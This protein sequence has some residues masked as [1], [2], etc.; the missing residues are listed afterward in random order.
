MVRVALVEGLKPKYAEGERQRYR[1]LLQDYSGVDGERIDILFRLIKEGARSP[2]EKKFLDALINEVAYDSGYW[3]SLDYDH[4]KKER[5]IIAHDG[6]LKGLAGLL[7]QI[8]ESKVIFVPAVGEKEVAPE[9]EP[10]YLKHIGWK[11]KLFL[12]GKD[13]VRKFAQDREIVLPEEYRTNGQLPVAVQEL[14]EQHGF[15]F[16]EALKTGI[17][18]LK[19]PGYRDRVIAAMAIKRRD[20]A[21][22][23]LHPHDFVEAAEFYTYCWVYNKRI[24]EAL[25]NKLTEKGDKYHGANAFE[26]PKRAP[27]DGK[28][29]NKVELHYFPDPKGEGPFPLDWMNTRVSCNCPHALNMRNFEERR[30]KMTRVVETMDTHANMVFLAMM[31]AKGITPEEAVNNMSPIP[32]AE[33]STIVDRMRYNI[34]QEFEGEEKGKIKTKRT[35]VGEAGIEKLIH[36]LA[37]LPEWTFERMFNPHEKVGKQLLKPMYI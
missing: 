37:K 24:I 17:G 11:N 2:K 20:G 21:E 9:D 1:R 18:V 23:R 8:D 22:L 34:V 5:V 10:D 27:I 6:N 28:R 12:N 35:Y 36:D 19:E 30:G 32:T 4:F 13:V 15:Y 14:L 3:Q 29:H 16:I 7:Q 33:F 26:V 25:G 31:R